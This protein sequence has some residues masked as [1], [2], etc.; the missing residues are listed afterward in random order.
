MLEELA[1]VLR[2]GTLS[3]MDVSEGIA[4][5]ISRVT[6]KNARCW[7]GGCGLIE[8]FYN[9]YTPQLR[10]STSGFSSKSYLLLSPW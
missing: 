10:I 9:L 5:H 7:V 8:L 3:I 4:Q 1:D 2:V 6:G